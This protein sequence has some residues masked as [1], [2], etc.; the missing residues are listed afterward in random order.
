MTVF[1]AKSFTG[2]GSLPR[3]T[4]SFHPG[5]D[6]GFAD[7]TPAAIRIDTERVGDPSQPCPTTNG[8]I[9]EPA[10]GRLFDGRLHVRRRRPDDDDCSHRRGDDEERLSHHESFPIGTSMTVLHSSKSP[11]RTSSATC[12]SPGSGSSATPVT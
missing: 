3:L 2:C 6:R 4:V 5:F 8:M 10:S 11:L 12:Q 7:V 9:V 1:P